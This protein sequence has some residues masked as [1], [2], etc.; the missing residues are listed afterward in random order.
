MQLPILVHLRDTYVSF[1]ESFIMNT[2]GLDEVMYAS[3]INILQAIYIIDEHIDHDT[4]YTQFS[5][6]NTYLTL[7]SSSDFEKYTSSF[8]GQT[9]IAGLGVILMNEVV[10]QR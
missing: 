7:G 2:K 10:G 1:I 6:L 3:S 9:F 4:K 8:I 5:I